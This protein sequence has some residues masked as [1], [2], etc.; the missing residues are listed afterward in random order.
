M[1]CPNGRREREK[2][3]AEGAVTRTAANGSRKHEMEAD[4][5]SAEIAPVMRE[6][7]EEVSPSEQKSKTLKK[8]RL[9]KMTRALKCE[10]GEQHS[11]R[12]KA[13]PQKRRAVRRVESAE[14]EDYV[15]VQQGLEEL[16]QEET[17]ELGSVPSAGK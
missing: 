4:C 8:L 11:V 16:G 14:T 1:G 10:T 6:V 2:L 13:P 3:A 17:E 9:G 7:D 5:W 15:S 12:V